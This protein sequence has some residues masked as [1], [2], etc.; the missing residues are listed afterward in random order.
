MSNVYDKDGLLEEALADPKNFV[1]C[2]SKQNTEND[3]NK[4]ESDRVVE[5]PIPSKLNIIL[6]EDYRHKHIPP[7]LKNL[8]EQYSALAL[9]TKLRTRHFS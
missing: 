1:N 5:F 7:G 9:Y 3:Q 4:S 6:Q 8:L 2:L